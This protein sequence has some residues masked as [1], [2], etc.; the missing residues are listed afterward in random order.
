[1]SLRLRLLISIGLVLA[2]TLLVGSVLIY[3]E[4]VN[5]VDTEMQAALAVGVR[6]VQNATDDAEEAVNPL[7]QLEL[8]V[9]DF[10]GNR[11]VRA[12]LM[13]N[14]GIAVDKSMLLMPSNPAPA[15]FNDLLMR[16]PEFVHI[17]LPPAFSRFGSIIL[18]TDS[19]NE[20][21]EAWS[22]FVVTLTILALFCALVL[23]LVYFTLGRP[24]RLLRDMS[25]AFKRV[26][27]RDYSPRIAETGAREITDLAR[28]F[29]DMVMRLAG[30]ERL[31]R[32]L[33]A[34]LATV[35]EEE[36]TDLARDLHDEIGPL[37]FALNIDI[38][39]LQQQDW[40]RSKEKIAKQLDS[41]SSA[42]GGIQAHVRSMLGKLR[43]AVLLDLGLSQAVDNLVAFWGRRHEDVHIAVALERE[44]FGERLDATIYRVVQEALNN[45]LRHG[46]PSLIEIKAGVSEDGF[47]EV[48]VGDNG[49]GLAASDAD[50]GFGLTGMKERVEFVGGSLSVSNRVGDSGV[51]VRAKLPLESTEDALIREAV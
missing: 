30:I 37:L 11:H 33:Q 10:N 3:F 51:S 28:C 19:H 46:H 26:G 2:F 18:T 14:D 34:Q 1:M 9:E 43:P 16:E 4:A 17:F 39:T 20:I 36:R 5:K 23:A 42:I 40:S 41:M 35:Q 48:E 31:N 38:S 15:W 24:L 45:A 49:A 7:R 47:V 8:L 50:F 27:N 22:D 25:T 13:N 12:F 21:D 44:S 6:T 29:N 32:Q